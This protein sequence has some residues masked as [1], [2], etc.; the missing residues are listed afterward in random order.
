MALERDVDNTSAAA[1]KWLRMLIAPGGSLGGA[2]PRP[3]SSI[4]R[5]GLAPVPRLR[6]ESSARVA[7]P[8]LNVS[9][10]DNAMDL[11][12]ARSVAPYFRVTRKL[13]EEIIARN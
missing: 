4:L 7:R 8:E 9:E 6:H 5:Q 12:L 3:V 1:D 11:D 13:A 10:A 2:R